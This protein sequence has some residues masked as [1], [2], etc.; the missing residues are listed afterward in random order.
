MDAKI[1]RE[2]DN[3]DLEARKKYSTMSLE[4]LEKLMLEEEAKA[5]KKLAKK[6]K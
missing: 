4:E 1:Y 2:N 5:F 6:N 3:I